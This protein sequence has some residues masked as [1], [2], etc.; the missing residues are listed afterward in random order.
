LRVYRERSAGRMAD[1][2]SDAEQSSAGGCAG[3]SVVAM[4]WPDPGELG[5][6]RTRELQSD[7]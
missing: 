6:A 1:D 2:E 7:V 5:L 3:D 4:G